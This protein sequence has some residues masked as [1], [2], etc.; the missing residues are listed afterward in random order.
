MEVDPSDSSPLGHPDKDPNTKKGGSDKDPIKNTGGSEKN[1]VGSVIGSKKNPIANPSKNLGGSKVSRVASSKKI[2]DLSRVHGEPSK[3][4]GELVKDL[5]KQPQ[6]LG[7]L[8][9]GKVGELGDCK[10]LVGVSGGLHEGQGVSPGPKRI[11]ETLGNDLGAM[12]SNVGL[13]G[14]TR[15]LWD[16]S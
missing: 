13:V 1:I 3:N 14:T 8:P 2:G 10:N 6:E 9:G 12:E 4:H 5:G 7:E 16:S 15:E 11:R